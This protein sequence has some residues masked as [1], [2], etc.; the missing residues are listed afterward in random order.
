MDKLSDSKGTSYLANRIT[1]IAIANG[2]QAVNPQDFFD[3][4]KKLYTD[5]MLSDVINEEVPKII[6]ECPD[7]FKITGMYIPKEP[8]LE[9]FELYFKTRGDSGIKSAA[10]SAKVWMRHV[11]YFFFDIHDHSQGI[12]ALNEWKCIWEG[13]HGYDDGYRSEP[14]KPIDSYDTHTAELM[15]KIVSETIKRDSIEGLGIDDLEN[16]L[17]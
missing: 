12:H 11:G 17:S 5:C 1:N 9:L 15:K 13:R 6:A 4:I 10:H 8:G 7:F 2:F 16:L 3:G 14:N